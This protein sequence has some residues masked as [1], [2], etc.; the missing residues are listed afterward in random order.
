M[1]R[2]QVNIKFKKGKKIIKKK[3][4]LIITQSTPQNIAIRR[5]AEEVGISYDSFEVI[6]CK[7]LPWNFS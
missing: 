6:N 5:W 1:H 2:E 4:V 3:A 7:E